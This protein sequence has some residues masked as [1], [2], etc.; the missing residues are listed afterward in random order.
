[1]YYSQTKVRS[2]INA[3]SFKIADG[4]R[5][6]KRSAI[7]ITHLSERGVVQ[8]SYLMLDYLIQMHSY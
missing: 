4:K 7:D 8:N 5:K 2:L 6:E 1:M 3:I